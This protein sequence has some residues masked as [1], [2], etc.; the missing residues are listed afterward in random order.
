MLVLGLQGSPRKKGNT[1]ILLS[2]FME[3]AKQSGAETSVINVYEQ[4]IDPCIECSMCER[5]GACSIQDD[6]SQE[7]YPL[8]RRADIVVLASPIFFYNVTA[9][10]KA[11]IDRTQTFWSRKY[12]L[13]MEDPRRKNRKGFLLAIGA[14]KGKTLF[15]GTI[16]TAKYFFDAIGASS[17]GQLT[18]PRIEERGEINQHP[19]AISD[20]K[21]KALEIVSPLLQRKK[22]LFACRENACRSQM[23]AAFANYYAGDVV[24]A[25]CGGSQAIESVNTNMEQ[26]MKETGLDMGFI[27]PQSID[28]AIQHVQPD[29]IVTMGCGEDGCPF[30][31]GAKKIDWDLEDPSGKPIEMMRQVRDDILQRV[32]NLA[33][34]I[35][36]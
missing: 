2:A 36:Q 6:M 1:D 31:P 12:R 34:T 32:Q 4:K 23:A 5:M 35:K 14:T 10:L 15:H 16:A 28:M 8:L 3:T 22:I 19:T 27:K 29:I 9:P 20:A 25:V 21:E 26:V 7:I 11:V 33:H 30:V 18:Y 13:N 17:L 24:E